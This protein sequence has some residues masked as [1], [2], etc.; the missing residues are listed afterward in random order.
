M[1]DLERLLWNPAPTEDKG[2]E[3]GRMERE[4]S[5]AHMKGQGRINLPLPCFPTTIPLRGS[6]AL[7]HSKRLQAH[8]LVATRETLP[9]DTTSGKCFLSALGLVCKRASKHTVPD[10]FLSQ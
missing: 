4:P 3:G 10:P 1:A 6:L 8:P 2:S 5:W 7:D 9:S